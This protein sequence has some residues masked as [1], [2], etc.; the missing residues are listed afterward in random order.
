M[1]RFA[2][3][4]AA[5][6]FSSPALAEDARDLDRLE[7]AFQVLNAAD[8][9]STEYCMRRG[10]CHEGN[11]LFGKSPS[12]GR[13]LAIKASEGIVHYALAR[14]MAERDPHGA[15]IFEYVSIGVQGAVVTANLR[16]VF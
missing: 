12:T 6:I 13:L 3:F 11:P 1:K 4:L 16:F 15:R 2:L 5:L 7:I 9:A 10:T 14:W 8:F